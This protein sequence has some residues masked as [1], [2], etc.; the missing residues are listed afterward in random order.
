MPN[1]K[2][3]KMSALETKRNQNEGEN[4]CADNACKPGPRTGEINA[5]SRTGSIDDVRQ[6]LEQGYQQ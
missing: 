1:R 4:D 6:Y 2:Q 3:V 5:M